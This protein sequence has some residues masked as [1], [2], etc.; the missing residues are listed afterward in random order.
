MDSHVQISK[1]LIKQFRISDSDGRCWALDLNTKNIVRLGTK[2]IGI[3]PNYYNDDTEK[4]LSSKYETE[5]GNLIADLKQKYDQKDSF[6]LTNEQIDV[7]AKFLTELQSRDPVVHKETE[8]KAVIAKLVGFKVN[9][10]VVVRTTEKTDLKDMYFKDAY[11][12][13]IYNYSAKKFVSSMKGFSVMMS[14]DKETLWWFPLTPEI[15]I[16]YIGKIG[17][18]KI[19]QSSSI[20]TVNETKFVEYFND[21]I[22]EQEI[23]HNTKYIFGS[24]KTELERIKSKFNIK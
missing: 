7:I 18:S 13:V 16:N 24:D 1:C 6:I 9:P 3:D 17:F 2:K 21:N 11:P 15:G 14:E 20:G 8:D 23:K 19:Y 5:M 22:S 10:S 12:V 4:Y